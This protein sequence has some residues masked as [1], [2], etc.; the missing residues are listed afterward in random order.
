MLHIRLIAVGT[1]KEQFYMDAI[2]EY[3]KRL[4]KYCKFEVIQIKETTM[5]RECVD[6]IDR[7]KGHVFSFDRSG[8]QISSED[9][10]NRIGKLSQTT[11]EITFIIGGSYGVGHYID[12][13]VNE[14][15][16]F[17]KIT[18]PHQLFRVVA[19]E[20]IYRAFTI[21]SNEKYHK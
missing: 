11:S 14:K 3:T 18:F 2:K 5:K 8:D 13:H 19:V 20:Q 4:S 10:A 7:L 15:I 21:Q 12:K 1:I 17:G 16:S 6:I 9:L